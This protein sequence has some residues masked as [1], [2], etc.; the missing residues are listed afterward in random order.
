MASIELNE[1]HI[2]PPAT[3]WQALAKRAVAAAMAEAALILPA[4][5]I[6]LRLTN[7]AEVHALNRDYRGKDKPTNVLS[8]PQYA[9][10]DIAD[11]PDSDAP[12]I[13]LGDIVL[14]Y[15]TCAVEAADKG[16][17]LA[18]HAAHL[19][20]HGAL[21]LLGYD[22]QNDIAAEEMEALE[23]KALASLGISDPY[24]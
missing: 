5:E 14:A 16:V 6:S 1:D 7:D 3:D 18:D 19:I 17:S 22:H 10:D 9:P 23:T 21:H 20:I 4:A 13:L 24:R 11:L 2:W 15:E 12:E 8:F